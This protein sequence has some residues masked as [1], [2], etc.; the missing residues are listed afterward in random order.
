LIPQP[1]PNTGGSLPELATI[2]A[3]G[4]LSFLSRKEIGR[5]NRQVICEG[6]NA[7]NRVAI[8]SNPQDQM[9]RSPAEYSE[10]FV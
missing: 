6:L 9:K 7:R 10:M 8:T 4:R 1:R 2:Q 3:L 5:D